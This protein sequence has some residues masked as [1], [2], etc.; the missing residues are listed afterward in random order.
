M[1]VLYTYNIIIEESEITFKISKKNVIL[2]CLI[3]WYVF[4]D[5]KIV[6]L[7][8]LWIMIQFCGNIE[9]L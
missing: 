6:L 7:T 4:K 5:K 2:T 1:A 9:N 3:K 8:I